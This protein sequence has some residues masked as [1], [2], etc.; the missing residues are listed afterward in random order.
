MPEQKEPVSPGTL[1]KSDK[2]DR[3]DSQDAAWAILHT[4]LSTDELK[5]FCQDIER[6]FRIN[7]MLNFKTWQQVSPNRYYFT[8]QNISQQPPFEFELIL[9]SKQLPGG[10]QI[11][12]EQGLKARTTFTIEPVSKSDDGAFKNQSK[13]IITDFYDGFPEN[14]RKQQLHHVDKSITVWA[15][16]L[17]RYLTG[18]KKWSRFGLWRWYMRHIWQPMKPMGRRITAILFWVTFFEVALILLG[19]GVYYLE[20]TE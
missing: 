17:Q 14:E 5:L 16:D 1:D 18:W 10:I 3:P 7:P 19:V 9:T 6:L 2:S 11:D 13:L 15:N 8:G 20:Y 12:Y 4:P